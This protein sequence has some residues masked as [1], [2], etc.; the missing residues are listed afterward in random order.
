MVGDQPFADSEADLNALVFRGSSSFEWNDKLVGLALL[1]QVEPTLA[2][3][4]LVHK[5]PESS[6]STRVPAQ[7]ENKFLLSTSHIY[8]KVV[9]YRAPFCNAP[10]SPAIISPKSPSFVG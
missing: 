1:I 3:P 9:P 10:V 5:A 7:L 6:N 2:G 4:V 8:S